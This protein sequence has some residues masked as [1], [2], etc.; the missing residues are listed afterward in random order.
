MKSQESEDLYT[1]SKTTYTQIYQLKELVDNIIDG[2][3]KRDE[4]LVERC[5]KGNQQTERQ[6]SSQTKGTKL[7]NQQ[8]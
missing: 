4:N 2:V 1:I 6:C 7:L 8:E 5:T 3:K